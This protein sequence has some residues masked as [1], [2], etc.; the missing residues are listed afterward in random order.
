M[1]IFAGSGL[2]FAQDANIAK[3]SLASD[4]SSFS[5]EMQKMQ[6]RMKIEKNKLLDKLKKEDPKKYEQMLKQ[7]QTSEKASGISAE[8]REKKISYDSAKSKLYPLIKE[9]MSAQ[10]D[11]LDKEIQRTEQKLE[12]LKKAKKNPDFLIYQRIDSMLGKSSPGAR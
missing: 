9:N 5:K 2:L 11:S 1:V 8:Y 4:S 6:E 12:E 3:Q 10:V 7:E